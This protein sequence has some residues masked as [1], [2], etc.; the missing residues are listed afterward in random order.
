MMFS[1]RLPERVW[2]GEEEEEEDQKNNGESKQ[3]LVK[4]LIYLGAL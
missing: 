3:K 4:I 1:Y 2:V